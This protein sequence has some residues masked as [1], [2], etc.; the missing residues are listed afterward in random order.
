MLSIP[1]NITALYDTLLVQRLV[2]KPEWGLYKKW[3][4]F[5]LDF[6]DK[7]HLVAADQSS[8]PA[9]IDKLR[10]KN[11]SEMSCLHAQQ[12]VLLFFSLDL[13]SMQLKQAQQVVNH[14]TQK[15]RNDFHLSGAEAEAGELPQYKAQGGENKSVVINTPS[16]KVD[17]RG[18]NNKLND[19]AEP[20]AN[21]GEL[22]QTGASWVSVYD[23]LVAEIKL[24]HYSPKTLKVYRSW[25]RKFQAFVKSKGCRLLTQQDVKDF[26]TDLAVNKNVAASTQNQAFN[27]LLFLFKQVLKQEFGELKD[28]PRAKRKRYIPVVLSRHE[29]DTMFEVLRSPFLLPSKLL[30]G[31]GLR[32]SEC[33]N[34]RLQDFNL[35]DGVLTIHNGKGKKDRTVPL[36]Q[37]ILPEIMHQIDVVSTLYEDDMAVNFAGVFL[38]DQVSQKYKNA[39]REF[40]WQWFF[41][42]KTLT[43]LSDSKEYKRYHLHDTQLQK[44]IRSATKR[45]K[46]LK[47]VTAH[48]FR[49]SFASHLLQANYDIRTIQ[50]LMGHSD[51]KT[52]MIY[53]QTVPSLTLKEAK[54]PLDF[55]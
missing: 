28:V 43:F 51:V 29:V 55:N 25:T 36:P 3:L 15:R 8:L 37:S 21:Y 12:A 49:H 45:A 14:S 17:S 13:Q 50:V 20:Q 19:V 35:E 47:R 7:Y 34:L 38:P 23:D 33:L 41:P 52:T 44:G 6:C 10:S 54:S 16:A 46:L 48:T 1:S 5:Y 40:I 4:R 2:P 22:K 39:G 42:A 9:F 27:A 32:I 31:C 30:Y 53:T 26:L 18:V 24:R 11:Q